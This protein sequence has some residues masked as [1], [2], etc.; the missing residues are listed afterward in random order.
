MGTQTEPPT[1]MNHVKATMP[2]GKLAVCLT[3]CCQA[4]IGVN[5]SPDTSRIIDT[6][7]KQRGA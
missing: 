4:R 5:D 2:V 7:M 3:S 6:S 1:L